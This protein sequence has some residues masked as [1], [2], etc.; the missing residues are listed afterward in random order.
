MVWEFYVSILRAV[1]LEEPG[2]EITVG[3]VQ[4]TFSPNELARFLGYERNLTA[5]PNLPLRDEDWPTKAEVFRTLLG[6]DTTI[7][8]GSYMQ[9]GMLLPFWRIMH[10]ILC[11]TIN[12]KTHT[13]K[14]SYH[15]VK[16]MY[17]VVV[18]EG[19]DKTKAIPLGPINKLTTLEDKVDHL[20]FEWKKE[21]AAIQ[22]DLRSMAS[23][24]QLH[25][26]TEWV[27]LI[28][29]HM[30]RVRETLLLAGDEQY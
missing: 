13:M 25:A 4:V 28:E 10:L 7:L 20:N 6:Q 1:H 29:E 30:A 27:L 9:H 19:A 14:L 22:S 23:R 16:F 2:M 11:S 21:V 12:L 18:P 24:A 3:N 5:F 17:L 8:E 26:L 15:R